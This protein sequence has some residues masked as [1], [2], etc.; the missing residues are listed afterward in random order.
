MRAVSA[1]CIAILF[2]CQPEVLAQ[3]T[4]Q[5]SPQWTTVAET[6]QESPESSAEQEPEADAETLE[7]VVV[8]ATK[9][10]TPISELGVSVSVITE[11]EITQQGASEVLEVLRNVPGVNILQDGP[12]GSNAHIF[13]RGG[14][15]NFTM[16][17]ID[18]V[19]LND[20][21]GLFDLSHLPLDNVERI[22]VIRGPQSALYGADAMTGVV[23]IITKRGEGPPQVTASA[24][25]GTHETFRGKVGLSGSTEQMSY[26]FAAS[27]YDT[28]NL[29]RIKNDRYENGWLS[30]RVGFDLSDATKLSLITTY[31]K[32]ETGNP[33][34]TEFL[35]EDADD[36]LE[37]RQF[38]FTLVFDQYLREWWQHVFQFSHFDSQFQNTDPSITTSIDFVT[39]YETNF[40]RETLNYQHNFYILDNYILSLG[41]EWQQENG[42]ILSLSDFGFGPSITEIDETR[43]NR[44]LF[45]QVSADFWERL[46]IVAGARYD[47][48]TSFGTEVSPRAAASYL[49]KETD[50]RLKASYGEGI[51]N[52]SFFELFAPFFGNPNLEAEQNESWEVG[53]EQRLTVLD[54]PVFLGAT[55]FDQDFTDLIQFVGSSIQNFDE[56]VVR[57]IET[58]LKIE[59]PHNITLA[60]AYTYLLKAEFESG[61]QE[62][63]D[64]LR[65]PKHLAAVTLNYKRDKLNVNLNATYTGERSDVNPVTFAPGAEADDFTKLDL[66]LSYD[67][68]DNVQLIGLVENLLDEDI[69][70]TLGFESRGISFL[71]GVR[72]V[73]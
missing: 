24:E 15:S 26:S 72:G 43:I 41:G 40:D 47:D 61:S 16:I 57:G 50:T 35:P 9:L 2:L 45:A 7:P 62:G 3:E 49:V 63:S 39:D 34:P 70:Q 30:G 71:G 69:E 19:K 48:N 23:N 67:L 37:N 53:V 28:A 25:T 60:G 46:N 58:E 8:T 52:P 44:A 18:G 65:R 21:G 64:L 5:A 32:S 56:A 1:V 12:P 54:M 33:G 59:F 20:D 17:M 4:G 13:L 10:E 11:E 42:D 55:Y 22:E 31:Q 36:T 73:F 51:K 27:F 29:S 14:E 6:T 38:T 66:A 68:T